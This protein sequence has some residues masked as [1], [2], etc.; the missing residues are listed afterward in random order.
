MIDLLKQAR[1]FKEFTRQELQEIA[2]ICEKISFKNEERIFEAET[3]AK[4]LYIVV[5][6]AVALNFKVTHY[7]ALK[8]MTLDRKFRGEAFGWSALT[9]PYHYTL[10]AKAM[11]DSEL[12][13][14]KEEDIKRLCAEDNHLG[15]ILMKN[16][17]E[18]IGE[19]FASVQKIVIDLIQQNLSEKER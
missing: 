19:R 13:R 12:L 18:I 5:K 16:I 15:Y 2:K 10:S 6:G 7:H 17:A 1:V 4:Y 9:E 11:Q 3:P 14:I 8:E